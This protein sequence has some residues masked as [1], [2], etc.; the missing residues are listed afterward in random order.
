M[1]RL[2]WDI[3]RIPARVACREIFWRGEMLVH[4]GAAAF[5]SVCDWLAQLRAAVVTSQR[6]ATCI[7]TYPKARALRKN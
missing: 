7:A 6:V 2:A 1:L 5:D 4:A 3:L